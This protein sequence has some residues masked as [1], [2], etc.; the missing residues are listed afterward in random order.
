MRSRTSAVNSVR[1]FDRATGSKR[2]WLGHSCHGH[3]ASPHRNPASAGQP[4]SAYPSHVDPAKMNELLARM[5]PDEIRD[6]FWLVGVFEDWGSMS[7]AEAD[8]WR[9]VVTKQ[10][11]LAMR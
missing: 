4:E 7:Q 3:P 11:F 10:Q 6:G 8:E 9:R 5:T 1:A 2:A